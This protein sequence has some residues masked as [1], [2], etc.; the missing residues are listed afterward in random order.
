MDKKRSILSIFFGIVIVVVLYHFYT[1]FSLDD[2]YS[3]ESS[4]YDIEDGMIM[5]I[6]PYTDV[7]LFL[8]YFDF[9]HCTV[10][11]RDMDH[12]SI[13]EGYVYNG[14]VTVVESQNQIVATYT[15]VIMGDVDGDGEI[16]DHDYSE[17]GRYLVSKEEIPS[18]LMKSMDIDFDGSIHL[19]DLMLLRKTIDDGYLGLDLN[20]D[21]VVL[22]SNEKI[23]VVGDVTPSY[24]LNTNLKWSSNDENVVSVDDSGVFVGK[25]EGEAVVLVQTMDGSISKSVNVQVDNTIQLERYSGNV[26]QN[27]DALSVYIKAV[28]YD[29]ISCSSSDSSRISCE[30]RGKYLYISATGS[31]SAVITVTS[32]LYGSRTFDATSVA[33]NISLA[34]TD[35]SCLPKYSGGALIISTFNVGELSFDISDNEIISDAYVQGRNFVFKSGGKTGRGTV[36]INGTNTNRGKVFTMDVYQLLFPDIGQAG[37]VGEEV[38]VNMIA[39][40]MENLSCSSKNEAIATCRIEDNKLYVKFLA[41]G[42][43]YIDVKNTITFNGSVYNC[44]EA[45]LIVVGV[46]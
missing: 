9:D 25:N 40:N 27:G 37:S 46:S 23:R 29:G 15:N 12:H 38:L 11:V 42:S 6:S 16:L 32:P 41:T 4:V 35:Y 45:E 24:G 20:R 3:F 17:F 22:Q 7:S 18:Y 13:T 19:N 39:E 1:T 33:T 30:V 8:S 21:N 5:N 44:G 31:G 10:S 14:S 28:D 43:T 2:N 36:T 26:Y 34:F